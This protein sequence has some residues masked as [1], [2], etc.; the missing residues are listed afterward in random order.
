[1]NNIMV[2]NIEVI[3]INDKEE[4]E[5]ILVPHERQIIDDVITIWKQDSLTETL[6]VA[7]LHGLVKKRHPNWSLSEKRLRS[8]LK[9]FGLSNTAPTYNYASEIKSKPDP[10]MILPEKVHL[11][12]TSKRGKGLYCKTP[13]AKGS[14]IWEEKPFF[15]ITPLANLNLIKKG[16]ACTYCGKL[17]SS[18]A[19]LGAS[20]IKTR[21]STVVRGLDC[22]VCQEMWCSIG[23]KK[24]NSH[25]HALLK[26]LTKGKKNVVNLEYYLELEDYCIKEDWNALFAIT[27]IWAGIMEDNT[28]EKLT[29]FKSMARVSQQVRYKALDSS[30]GSF[31]NFSGGALFVQE[32]Q[33]LLWKEGFERFSKVF[34]NSITNGDINYE[35]F[36][37]ML[38]SYNINNLDSSIFRIHSHLNHTCTPTVNVHTEISKVEG[39]KVYALKDLKANEELTTSYVNPSHTVQQRQRELRC[40]WGFTCN[41]TKCKEELSL[42]NLSASSNKESNKSSTSRDKV[43]SG[44]QKKE[45]RKSSI[46]YEDKSSIRNMLNETKDE[47]DGEGIELGAPTFESER[48]KSVRFDEKVI[49]SE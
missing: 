21:S 32:Q 9:K 37:M 8:L 34:P 48:R 10:N 38:G 23:C 24:S 2:K 11:V 27:L 43:V 16:R 28:D 42:Q 47:L 20:S 31:D 46:K 14:L 33:E 30:A 49:V 18:G 15:F 35:E 19:L 5:E 3:S 22:N 1:M 41:C 29:Y 40:N 4:S 17:L 36:L 39:I 7:K 6:G 44:E 26:H 13:I 45:R 12:V 25:I